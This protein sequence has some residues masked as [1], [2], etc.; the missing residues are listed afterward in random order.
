MLESLLLADL[1]KTGDKFWVIL[2]KDFSERYFWTIWIKY[3]KQIEICASSYRWQ[4]STVM[5]LSFSAGLCQQAA[6]DWVHFVSNLGEGEVRMTICLCNWAP[7]DSSC[8]CHGGNQQD[9]VK[10]ALLVS[11]KSFS[12]STQVIW[13]M[14]I[15]TEPIYPN[16]QGA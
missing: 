12:Y 6:G 16:L 15:T 1:M 11:Q 13:E 5:S 4:S 7:A 3:R 8:L 14:T 9:V 2:H 10:H